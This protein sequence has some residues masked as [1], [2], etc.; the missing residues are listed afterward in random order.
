MSRVILASQSPRR[1]E[2]L[3]LLNI[4]YEAIPADINE[5][6]DP[7][8]DLVKEIEK[9]SYQK[10]F[11]V[12]K[13]NKDA[14]VIGSDTIVKINNEVLGKPKNEEDAK[15]MLNETGCDAVMIGRGL[16]GNPFLIKECLAYIDNNCLYEKPSY[17]DKIDMCL[18]HI[19]YLL[20]FKPK[21]I[22]AF[23]IRNHVAWYYNNSEATY[24]VNGNK[25]GLLYNWHAV[26]HLNDN[27]ATLMPGWHVPTTGEWDALA[28]AVGGSGGAGTKLKANSGWNSGN[29]SDDFGFSVFPA[30]YRGSGSFIYLGS[31]ASFWSATEN[32]SSNAY[33]RSFSTGASMGSYSNDKSDY[34]CSVRLVK[35]S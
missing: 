12:F 24:G 22:V 32:S 16:L 7:N 25:Y 18:K 28:N 2:L 29:G 4:K 20:E 34:A 19:N 13:D 21:K 10:A 1:K 9:L 11:H 6:I 8:N 14:L 3:S 15:R 17:I 27:R 30:G 26:K 5:L 31:Y 33:Y 23:E 35:D